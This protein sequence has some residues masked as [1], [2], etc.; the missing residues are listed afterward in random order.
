[1]E[2]IRNMNKTKILALLGIFGLVIGIVGLGLGTFAL[3]E[4]KRIESQLGTISEDIHDHNGWYKRLDSAVYTNPNFTLI[5]VTALTIT[6]E[7]ESNEAVYFSY[8]AHATLVPDSTSSFIG[9]N[10]RLD[11]L[12]LFSPYITSGITNVSAD[13][14]YS[15]IAL[16]LYRDNLTAGVH[17]I[18]VDILGSHVGNNVNLNT[19]YVQKY[20]V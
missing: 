3:S 9:I 16:Q 4:F 8:M 5:P 13:G 14:I 12:H 6:F 19:L 11:G 18:T 17:T 2:V 1:M 10:F 20:P 15:T 7:L